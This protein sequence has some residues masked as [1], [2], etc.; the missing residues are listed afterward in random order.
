MT[1]TMGCLR[2]L[3]QKSKYTISCS[4]RTLLSRFHPWTLTRQ[5]GISY[6]RPS[7]ITCFTKR[8]LLDTFRNKTG[9]KRESCCRY[10]HEENNGLPAISEDDLEETFTRGHGPGGQSVN[11][12]TN[13][14]VLKHIPTGVAVKVRSCFDTQGK[15][16]EWMH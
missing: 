1:T 14:C 6:G 4:A 13:C 9:I 3:S 16:N 2:I 11:K 15:M 5:N 10:L 7:N 12:S 8:N